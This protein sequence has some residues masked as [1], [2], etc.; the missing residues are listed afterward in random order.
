MA[1]P[2][3]EF[4][5]FNPDFRPKLRALRAELIE[6]EEGSKLHLSDPRGIAPEVEMAAE[7]GA[8]LALLTGARP[9]SELEQ[10][11]RER[12]VED[13]S[14]FVQGFLGQ[15]DELLMLESDHFREQAALIENEDEEGDVRQARF[16]GRSYP[17]DPEELRAFLDDKLREGQKRLAPI[18]LDAARVVGIVTPHI[19]FHRGGHTETASYMPLVKNVEATGKPFDLF[20]VLGI[21]HKGVAYPFAATGQSFDTPFGVIE[22]DIEFMNALDQ[23][24]PTEDDILAE[25]WV[26]GDEHSL[27]FTAVMLGYHEKLRAAKIAPFAVGG[28]WDALKSKDS[29]EEAEPEV[30]RFVAALRKTVL[31]WES[32]GKKVG[33]IASVDGAHVGTQFGDSTPLTPDRLEEIERAD[34][35]WIADVEQG[36]RAKF[37]AH[38]ARDFNRFHVD[39]HPAVY[40]LMAAFP[41]L[42]GAFLDYDQAF[43]PDQNIVVSFTSMSLLAPA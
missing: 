13:A 26:H 7:Y 16:A 31:K 40:T 6:D 27:E 14:N 1:V 2:V 22:T 39:A 15:L 19:D 37:H 32:R 8:F 38:F 5:M 43:H 10:W 33:F 3:I 28:F 25:Q 29:P 4:T 35:D 9:V 24:L 23:S 17:A 20:I 12:G 36:D 30:A 21:A 42:R 41:E 34:K 18:T 11:L